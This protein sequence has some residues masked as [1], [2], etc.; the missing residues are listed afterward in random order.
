MST[1]S[2]YRG[3]SALGATRGT[4]AGHV[5]VAAATGAAPVG[6]GLAALG[7]TAG[8]GLGVPAGVGITGEV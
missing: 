2:V 8:V 7:V 6:V 1:V 3:R 5:P 4:G